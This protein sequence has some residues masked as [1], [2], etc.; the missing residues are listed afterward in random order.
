MDSQ[1]VHLIETASGVLV[2]GVL[3]TRLTAEEVTAAEATWAESRRGLPDAEH[4]HWDWGRKVPLVSNAGVAC[5]GLSCRGDMQGLMMTVEAGKVGR[6]PNQYGRPLVSVD[7][8]EAA[9]WNQPESPGGPRYKGVGTWLI[10]AAVLASQ[11]LG[12][13]GRIGLHSLRGAEGFYEYRC[14]MSPWGQDPRYHE[15]MYYEFTADAAAEFV[16]GVET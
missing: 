12:C 8:L 4:T 11:E 1:T 16:R 5:H 3:N 10:W 14:R 15:L 2:E 9:P 6:L 13:D 7:F